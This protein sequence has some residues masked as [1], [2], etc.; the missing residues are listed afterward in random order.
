MY[1]LAPAI[2]WTDYSQFKWK[3]EKELLKEYDLEDWAIYYQRI[4]DSRIDAIREIENI[5]DT[6]RELLKKEL[7]NDVYL[8]LESLKEPKWEWWLGDLSV[9]IWKLHNISSLVATTSGL[10]FKLLKEYDLL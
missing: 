7:Q 10:A 2:E 6:Q 3:W 4:K 1:K 8:L 5:V 9:D